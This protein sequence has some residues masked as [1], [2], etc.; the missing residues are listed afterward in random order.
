NIQD[1]L[2]LVSKAIVT[3]YNGKN[4]NIKLISTKVPTKP[5][6]NNKLGRLVK[7]NYA[8]AASSVASHIEK[9]KR[10][11][12]YVSTSLGKLQYQSTIYVLSRVGAYVYKN[13]VLAN[14]VDV[15]ASSQSKINGGTKSVNTGSSSSSVS[16]A[17]ISALATSLTKGCTTQLQK[18]TVIYNWVRDKI[19]YE[20]YY[21]TKYGAAKTLSLKKGNC[22]DQ[23]HLLIALFRKVGLEARYVNGN[24]DFTS[25][26]WIGHVWGEVKVGS[27]WYTVDTTSSRNSFGVVKNWN[28]NTEKITGRY[29]SISF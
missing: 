20:F 27:K 4:S 19:A 16:T 11:P 28:T 6:G 17:S 3:K 13:K 18:A 29:T 9:N 23:T 24:C 12:N 22:V 7:K 14:Y 5:S 21:N 2:Y 8:A 15:T 10:A 26:G 25:S 1:F